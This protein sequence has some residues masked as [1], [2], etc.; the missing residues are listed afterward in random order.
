M[1]K[2]PFHEYI[3]QYTPI[4]T[5]QAE[6]ERLLWHQRL[7]HPSDYYLYNAHKHVKGV[8]QFQHEHPVL[9]KCP[10][11][12]QAKQTKEPAGPHTTRTATAPYQGLSVDFSFS[13]VKSKDKSREIDFVG[14]NGEASWILVSDHFTQRLH[15]D[16]RVSKASPIAWLRHFLKNHSPHIRDKYVFLDQGG[17]LYGNTIVRERFKE[18]HYEIRP[19]G[20][21]S[22][23]QN[24]PVERAHCTVS[25]ALRAMLH[26]ANLEIKF[27]PY[28][29][30]HYVFG[31][32]TPCLQETKRLPPWN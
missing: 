25:N 32:R 4:L 11:C 24:G 23:N 20:S 19:T 27:W 30:H 6:T 21:D 14:L 2:M 29:F 15:G 1:H 31:L 28:A 9:D 26:G 12:I 5:I 16:T 18:F 17:E 8:P 3:H 10:T 13:G 7:G 22:S